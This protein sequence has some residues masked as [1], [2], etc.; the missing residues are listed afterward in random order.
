MKKRIFTLW[1]CLLA[2]AGHV[3]AQDFPLDSLYYKEISLLKENSTEIHPTKRWMVSHK[4]LGLPVK[5]LLQLRIQDGPEGYSLF[6]TFRFLA[7]YKAISAGIPAEAFGTETI[8]YGGSLFRFWYMPEK[9]IKIGLG[10][11]STVAANGNADYVYIIMPISRKE[12]AGFFLDNANKWQRFMVGAPTVGLDGESDFLY[13]KRK[14]RNTV[15]SADSLQRYM[16]SNPSNL[17][18]LLDIAIPR[19][20]IPA[21]GRIYA[22]PAGSLCFPFGFA[23]KVIKVSKI[24]GACKMDFGPV[25]ELDLFDIN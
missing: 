23:G 21:V 19:R 14:L 6:C 8:N 1:C 12:L 2:V 5:D 22:S 9:R 13:R 16:L 7:N 4:S 15:L 17:S 11:T 20:D 24:N 18:V 10:I 3:V 25:D